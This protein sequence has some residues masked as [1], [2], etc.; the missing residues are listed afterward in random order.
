[1]LE[2]IYHVASSL[3][4]FIADKDLRVDWLNDFHSFDDSEVSKDFNAFQK[5]FDAIILGGH[6]YDFALDYGQ[7]MSPNT[8][9]WVFTSRNLKVLHPS[10]QL[11]QETPELVCK[12][13]DGK[14]IK[15][16][17]LMGGGKLAASFFDAGLINILQ[18][19][20]VPILLGQGVPLLSKTE[21]EPI[22]TL[23]ENK[24]YVNGIIRV[25]Y[26][27]RFR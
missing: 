24:Q 15:R 21:K 23:T 7:W 27:V 22:L 1:M 2:I 5:S 26:Q 13:M 20:I 12:K 18:V 6:T 10:I 9:S 17:W 14:G 25:T 4:G 3:D 16:A 8:P 11:T 19:S